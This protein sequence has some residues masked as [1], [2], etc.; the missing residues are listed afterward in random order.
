MNWVCLNKSICT[1][2]NTCVSN[3][4]LHSNCLWPCS[5]A[6]TSTGWVGL[7]FC[8]LYVQEHPRLTGSGSD[9]KVS[10][11]TGPQFKSLIRQTGRSS[12]SNL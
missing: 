3:I 1:T 7:W 10:Q 6:I 12:E 11:K 2:V 8:G 5:L 4:I 9:F